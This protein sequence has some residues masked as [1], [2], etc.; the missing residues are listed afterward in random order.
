VQTGDAR[1]AV[2][3]TGSEK[4]KPGGREEKNTAGSEEK[5]RRG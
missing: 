1:H 3:I 5:K 2:G 4:K